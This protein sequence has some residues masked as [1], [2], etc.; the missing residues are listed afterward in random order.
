VPRC[1][2]LQARA[3]VHMVALGAAHGGARHTVRP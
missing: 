1:V 2:R 3:M